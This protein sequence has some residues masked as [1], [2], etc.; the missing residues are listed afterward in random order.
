MKT[1]WWLAGLTVGLFIGWQTAQ[2]AT[3]GDGFVSMLEQRF[4]MR[5]GNTK[6]L[7]ECGCTIRYLGTSVRGRHYDVRIDRL[8]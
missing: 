5:P 2:V 8:D 4:A 7:P 1:V 3:A 6:V